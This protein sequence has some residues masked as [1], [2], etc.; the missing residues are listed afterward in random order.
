[1]PDQSVTRAALELYAP[2]L[3][4][5]IP[6]RIYKVPATKWALG[7]KGALGCAESDGLIT[8]HEA[9]AAKRQ[10]DLWLELDARVQFPL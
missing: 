3:L 10:I 9:T 8:Q 7:A 2:R 1:M 5:D 4:V 6:M